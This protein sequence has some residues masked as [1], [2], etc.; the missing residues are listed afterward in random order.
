MDI[1]VCKNNQL[2]IKTLVQL[3]E[4]SNAWSVDEDEKNQYLNAFHTC[5]VIFGLSLQAHTILEEPCEL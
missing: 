3:K 4:N 1:V 2:S 5:E